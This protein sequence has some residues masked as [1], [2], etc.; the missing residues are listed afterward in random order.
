LPPLVRDLRGFCAGPGT[1]RM[2]RASGAK[3]NGGI[4]RID[5]SAFRDLWHTL[6]GV[7][8]EHRTDAATVENANGA[9]RDYGN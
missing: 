5:D 8:A 2:R 9:R 7:T 6:N 3:K 1:L 4:A